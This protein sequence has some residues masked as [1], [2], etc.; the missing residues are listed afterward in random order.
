MLHLANLEDAPKLLPL[1]AACHTE[2]SLE[3]DDQTRDAG[4]IPLLEGSPYGCIWLIGP[5]KAPVGYVAATFSWSLE[6][7]GLIAN[8][9][10]IYVRPAVRGRNM[11]TEALLSVAKALQSSQVRALYIEVNDASTRLAGLYKRCGFALCD[12][13]NVM[14]HVL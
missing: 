6:F 11:G 12:P 10:E 5:R 7:G 3:H 4:F 14:R 13:S 8:I 9:S 2:T 1:V